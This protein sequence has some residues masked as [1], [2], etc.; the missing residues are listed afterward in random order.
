MRPDKIDRE[1]RHV[2]IAYAFHKAWKRNPSARDEFTFKDRLPADGQTA[3]RKLA[4]LE[5]EGRRKESIDRCQTA[6]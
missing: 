4:P 5:G 2:S 6:I 3:Y 1:T